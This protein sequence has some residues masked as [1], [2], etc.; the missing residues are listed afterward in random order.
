MNVEIGRPVRQARRKGG[1]GIGY[2]AV[3]GNK[4]GIKG[5]GQGRVEW[6]LG[7]DQAI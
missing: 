3:G 7:S 6:V 4:Y 1:L 5:R 2:P